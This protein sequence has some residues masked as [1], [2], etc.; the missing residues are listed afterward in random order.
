MSTRHFLNLYLM[1]QAVCKLPLV[2][3]KFSHCAFSYQQGFSLTPLLSHSLTHSVTK[4]LTYSL[5]HSV[6]KSLP[7]SL[8]YLL[9]HS[10]T[11]LLTQSLNHTLTQSLG[12]NRFYIFSYTRRKRLTIQNFNIINNIYSKNLLHF[13][14]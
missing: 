1:Y 11:P 4:S 7:Y 5:T 10:A 8:P 14:L 3:Y 9:R 12:C 13:I 2:F 6:T